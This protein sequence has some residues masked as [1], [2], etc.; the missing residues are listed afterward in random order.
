MHVW[1]HCRPSAPPTHQPRTAIPQWDTDVEPLPPR[2]LP[3]LLRAAR[4]ALQNRAS[5]LLLHLPSPLKT[6][7]W[8]HPWPRKKPTRL[9]KARRSVW[10]GP[11]CLSYLPTGP[12]TLRFTPRPGRPHTQGLCSLPLLCGGSPRRQY[13]GC[14]HALSVTC[15]PSNQP[16]RSLSSVCLNSLQSRDHSQ[17]LLFL[18]IH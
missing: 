16:S 4:G 1:S 15:S 10:S 8:L 13:L 14:C 6:L 7:L 5:L 11:T 2:L 9:P 3:L 18:F 17:I 12:V